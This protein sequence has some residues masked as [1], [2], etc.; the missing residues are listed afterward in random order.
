MPDTTRLELERA[1]L[2]RRAQAGDTSAREALLEHCQPVVYRWALVQ[3]GDHDEAEDVTQEV[4]VRLATRLHRYA[5][6]A[7]FTTWLYQVT[8]NA[9]RDL[10]RRL[11][12][13]LRLAGALTGDVPQAAPDPATTAEAHEQADLMRLL[14]S[15]LPARQREVLHLADLDGVPAVEI[16]GRLGLR[17]ATVRV[18]LLR[19]RRALRARILSG[20]PEIGEAP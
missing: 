14:I 16:A 9:A 1:D 13:H 17:P 4:L 5:G 2:V 10:R 20:Y 15:E 12:R 19:A 11:A 8:R 18:H 7:Q 6:R 3:T